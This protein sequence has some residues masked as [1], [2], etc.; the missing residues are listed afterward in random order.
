MDLPQR[1]TARPPARYRLRSREPSGDEAASREVHT[2][3]KPWLQSPSLHELMKY[4]S[5]PPGAR[6]V[7][8]NQI[9]NMA[10]VLRCR[11]ICR[12]GAR[13]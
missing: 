8:C 11:F 12:D 6:E 3:E 4:Q 9:A 7:C 13:L 1:G 5:E 10:G 2:G